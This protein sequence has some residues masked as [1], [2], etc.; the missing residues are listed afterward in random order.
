MKYYK[1]K[2]IN[3]NIRDV[4]TDT[5]LPPGYYFRNYREGDEKIWAYIEAGAGEFKDEKAA[6]ERFENEFGESKADLKERCFFLCHEEA[7]PIGTSMAWYNLDFH[8]EEYGRLHW[9]AIHPDFQGRKLA[10][11]LIA[12][13]IEKLQS[14]HDKAYLTSQTTSWIAIKIYLDFG[15]VPL[16]ESPD[17]KEAWRLLALKL[18]HPALSEFQF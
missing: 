18:K 3:N 10:R 15:F 4:K 16:L 5:T 17:C 11:P 12:K 7:G 14:L 2:M 9:V 6:L 1:V 13:A 8:G